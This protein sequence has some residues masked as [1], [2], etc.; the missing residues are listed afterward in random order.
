MAESMWDDVKKLSDLLYNQTKEQKDILLLKLRMASY[1]SKRESAFA[2][3]GGLVFKPLK[4]GKHD[5]AEDKEIKSALNELIQI[6]KDIKQTEKELDKLRAQTAGNR[7]ELGDEL[8]KTWEKTKTAITPKSEPDDEVKKTK[9]QTA[10]PVEPAKKAKKSRAK[11]SSAKSAK[12]SKKGSKESD[13][14]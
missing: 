10:P 4:D 1:S 9:S 7:S 3:L 6:E 8:G 2:R 12:E 13:E 11:S 14:S 5:I